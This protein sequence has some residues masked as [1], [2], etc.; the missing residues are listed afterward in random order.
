[1]GI[2][3]AETFLGPYSRVVFV[4]V[5]QK[6]GSSIPHKGE[7]FCSCFC[8]TDSAL[9]KKSIFHPLRDQLNE[10]CLYMR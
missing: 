5:K 10:Y 2:S 7:K 9:T 1:M 6:I 8:I 4:Y 3:N